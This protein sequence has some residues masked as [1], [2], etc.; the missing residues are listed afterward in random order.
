MREFTADDLDLLVALDSDPEVMHFITG[1]QPTSRD[2]LGGVVL[3]RWLRY[4]DDPEGF[5]FWAAEG[6]GSGEFIGWFHLR[7]SDDDAASPPELGY[8]IARQYWGRGL[9]T[10]GS[11]GVLGYAFN[12]LKVER[13][14][15]ET[16]VAH[17][18]SRRVMEKAG[19]HL[20]EYFTADWPYR[21]PGEELGD[22][23]YA[24]DRSEWVSGTYG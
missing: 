7:P 8:R 3:P 13:V 16:M 10:E 1:G 14:L 18:A 17:A 2:E 9:A 22:V 6:R 12:T 23:R 20:T 24:A 5:G 21:I 11:I 15:A 4:Y 19:L